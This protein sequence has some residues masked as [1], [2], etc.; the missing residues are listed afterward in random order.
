M[1]HEVIVDRNDLMVIL[2]RLTKL[3]PNSCDSQFLTVRLIYLGEA[4]PTVATG[5]SVSSIWAGK[6][7]ARSVTASQRP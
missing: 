7:S 2:Q 4:V 1:F 6:S 5:K 3:R